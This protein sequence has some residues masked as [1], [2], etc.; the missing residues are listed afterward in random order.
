MTD[1]PGPSWDTSGF[2]DNIE[3]I[4]RLGLTR[5]W[6]SAAAVRVEGIA[7]T[8]A[9]PDPPGAGGMAEPTVDLMSN[10]TATSPRPH[11]RKSGAMRATPRSGLTQAVTTA[12]AL[13]WAEAATENNE[14]NKKAMSPTTTCFMTL[15]SRGPLETSMPR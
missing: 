6:L 10:A 15:Q 2:N 7:G 5:F 4:I 8:M 14:T 12:D 9:A 3:L 1:G 11:E 13:C